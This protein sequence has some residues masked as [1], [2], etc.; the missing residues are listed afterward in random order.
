METFER[1]GAGESDGASALPSGD[2]GSSTAGFLAVVGERVRRQRAL[3]HMPRRCLAERSGVSERYLAQLESGRG[4]MSIA[5]LRK[6]ALA[7]ELPL[8]ELVAEDG[9]REERLSSS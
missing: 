5:R 9:D 2:G 1:A 6:V 4:N 7:L 3:L 8:A